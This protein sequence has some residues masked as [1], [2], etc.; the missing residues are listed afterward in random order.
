MK[1]IVGWKDGLT[2]LTRSG[3]KPEALGDGSIF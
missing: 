3:L 2:G 1:D